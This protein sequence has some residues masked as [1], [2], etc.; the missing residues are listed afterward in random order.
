MC[1]H[2]N[3]KQPKIWNDIF[4]LTTVKSEKRSKQGKRKELSLILLLY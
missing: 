4:L 3:M 1:M 2:K